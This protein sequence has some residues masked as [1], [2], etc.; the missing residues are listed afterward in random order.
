ML[1]LILYNVFFHELSKFKS[2]YKWTS[3]YLKHITKIKLELILNEKVWTLW[4]FALKYFVGIIIFIK[5]L[6]ALPTEVVKLPYP[7][8]NHNNRESSNSFAGSF[9]LK[10]NV[11]SEENKS[12]YSGATA[13][14]TSE[15]FLKRF[16]ARLTC[17]RT[18]RPQKYILTKI[19]YI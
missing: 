12:S 6:R 3:K 4:E 14:R 16:E 19:L 18:T 2:C 7:G 1:H 17:W 15:K 13:V 8:I 11:Q 9:G 5:R 10:S